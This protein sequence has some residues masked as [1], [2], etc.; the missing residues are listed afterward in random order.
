MRKETTTPGEYY[1][2]F[3]R[4]INKGNMFFDDR[5]RARFLFLIRT[6]SHLFHLKI[7]LE[8]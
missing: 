3:N 5:D 7:F 1:H 4:G 6:Y 8:K 2:I